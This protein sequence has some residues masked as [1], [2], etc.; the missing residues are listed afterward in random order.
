MEKK[1]YPI[2]HLW[3]WYHGNY[4]VKKCRD[5]DGL[6]ISYNCWQKME[7]FCDKNPTLSMTYKEFLELF[8]KH[9]NVC[10]FDEKER[11]RMPTWK[12]VVLKEGECPICKKLGIPQW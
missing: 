12:E 11:R 9:M 6:K 8:S 4:C 5:E 1:P 10:I 3:H 7:A 2:R